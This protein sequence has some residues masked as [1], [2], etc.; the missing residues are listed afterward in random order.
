MIRYFIVLIIINIIT[1]TVAIQLDGSTSLSTR[2]ER[3]SKGFISNS[4]NMYASGIS[5]NGA[6]GIINKYQFNSATHKIFTQKSITFDTTNNET[7]GIIQSTANTDIAYVLS[8]P[9]LYKVNLT[10]MT[11]TSSSIDLVDGFK[12][13]CMVPNSNTLYTAGATIKKVNGDTMTILSTIS[14]PGGATTLLSCLTHE[15]YIYFGSSNGRIVRL[16]TADDTTNV[17]N[18]GNGAYTTTIRTLTIHQ[19][20]RH[21]YAFIDQSGGSFTQIHQISLTTFTSTGNSHVI[22]KVEKSDLVTSTV[23]HITGNIYFVDANTVYCYGNASLTPKTNVFI[24]NSLSSMIQIGNTQDYFGLGGSSSIMKLTTGSNGITT[25]SSQAMISDNV[26]Q[27]KWYA[28][29]STKIVLLSAQSRSLIVYDT[30]TKT[31]TDEYY[32]LTNPSTIVVDQSGLAIVGRTDGSIT[33]I[34]NQEYFTS[35]TSSQVLS[36]GNNIVA[37]IVYESHSYHL[38]STSSNAQVVQVNNADL[39]IDVTTAVSFSSPRHLIYLSNYL[40]IFNQTSSISRLNSTSQEHI[41]TLSVYPSHNIADVAAINNNL[42]V[43]LNHNNTSIIVSIDENMKIVHSYS[44]NYH[45]SSLT[46]DETTN[47]LIVYYQDQANTT[48]LV[49]EGTRL[50]HIYQQS[51]RQSNVLGK[52]FVDSTQAYIHFIVNESPIAILSIKK[53]CYKGYFVAGSNPLNCQACA[54]GTISNSVDATG[55]QTCGISTYAE[56][57]ANFKCTN[58][59]MGTYNNVTG[60]T[61]SSNCTNCPAG[62]YGE[63]LSATEC[64]SCIPGTFSEQIGANTSQTCLKCPLGTYSP[65]TGASNNSF[66][67]DCPYGT[68]PTIEGAN[69]STL[70]IPCAAGSYFSNTTKACVNCPA[71]SYSATVGALSENTCLKCPAGTQSSSVGAT[72]SATC[73]DCSAG[74]YA[75]SNGSS[76]CAA[77]PISTYNPSSGS[78]TSSACIPCTGNEVTPTNASTSASQCVVCAAGTFYSNAQCL[79]CTAGTYSGANATSCTQCPPGTYS[80]TIA[81]TSLAVC[82]RCPAGTFSSTS[83]GQSQSVCTSCSPGSY[84][85]EGSTSCTLCNEG[86][87]AAT[88]GTTA[89]TGC[90]N[91]PSGS[92]T[93]GKGATSASNCSAITCTPGQFINVGTSTSCQPCPAGHF[94]TTGNSFSCQP[95]PTGSYQDNTGQS[96]CITCPAGTYGDN[97]ARTTTC[98]AC[99]AGYFNN[100]TGS[101]DASNCSACVAGTFSSTNGSSTC[102]NCPLRSFSSSAASSCTVCEAGFYRASN[103]SCVACE[104]GQNCPFGSVGS[105]SNAFF[106]TEGH[107][108]VSSI[109]SPSLRSNPIRDVLTIIKLSHFIVVCVFIGTLFIISLLLTPITLVCYRKNIFPPCDE[110]FSTSHVYK[111]HEQ[112]KREPSFFG[113]VLSILMFVCFILMT[114]IMLYEYFEGNYVNVETTESATSSFT[115]PQGNFVV[116]VRSFSNSDTCNGT[117]SS[118]GFN[119]N[120]ESSF[121]SETIVIGDTTIKTCVANLT[122]TN[123]TLDTGS[124][125]FDF[126]FSTSSHGFNFSIV[127]PYVQNSNYALTSKNIYCSKNGFCQG[128]S[129]TKVQLSFVGVENKNHLN[130]WYPLIYDVITTTTG[131]RSSVNGYTIGSTVTSNNEFIATQSTTSSL[132]L[133]VTTSEH[134]ILQDQVIVITIFAF[135]GQLVG[136]FVVIYIVLYI[137]FYCGSCI[138]RKPSQRENRISQGDDQ[139]DIKSASHTTPSDIGDRPP[140]K[141]NSF[142]KS[143]TFMSQPLKNPK[144]PLSEAFSEAEDHETLLARNKYENLSQLTEHFDDESSTSISPSTPH[145]LDT[146][147]ELKK[148]PNT[149]R[150]EIVNTETFTSPPQHHQA[151]EDYEDFAEMDTES[152]E[153]FDGP[154]SRLENIMMESPPVNSPKDSGHSL[155]SDITLPPTERQSSLLPEVEPP[156]ITITPQSRTKP[157]GANNSSLF[158]PYKKLKPLNRKK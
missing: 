87:Y 94:S 18:V 127:T 57:V 2:I 38:I 7:N 128:S 62:T 49:F 119:G 28:L 32:S 54:A 30:L 27:G 17:L 132:S 147:S 42:I 76:S 82:T 140:I 44:I 137:C 123:C 157:P 104:A 51:F 112:M 152:E 53:S 19:T 75:S 129:P 85:T 83:G 72:T 55:C 103:N 156:T 149:A 151:K 126:N 37:S 81:A 107:G 71:G 77:C 41:E 102:T 80:P 118:T 158:S 9:N 101:T 22:A 93:S 95:C 146:Y 110:C 144:S 150:T 90:T 56:G 43:L 74:F 99:P 24:G 36:S 16:N 136:C 14:L 115:I 3:F 68:S 15:G 63:T 155:V 154:L 69:S 58:C 31:K 109:S 116:S 96:S 86:T 65:T 88:F 33:K 64:I 133:S 29:N 4:I 105:L 61:H 117:V 1:L 39:T 50:G 6:I 46:V 91:C 120:S 138:C 135:I 13:G 23:D 114:Y 21:I 34:N 73:V 131:Y 45:V 145:N 108:L 124:A 143:N 89:S 84:S 78:N 20:D 113:L 121:S 40:Y 25:S 153:E 35:S 97:A 70:C 67:I 26:S 5:T 125:Q 10:S 12:T 142:V 60:N 98:V 148:I 141:S 66:C 59:S 47:T 92:T 106:S 100:Y 52:G 122:C 130:K 11:L 134:I 111:R 139:K 79:N 8:N 48:F